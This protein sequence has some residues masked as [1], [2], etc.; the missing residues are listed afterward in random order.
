MTSVPDPPFFA[1]GGGGGGGGGLC[2]TNSRHDLTDLSH[3]R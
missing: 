2:Q 1:G 3:G